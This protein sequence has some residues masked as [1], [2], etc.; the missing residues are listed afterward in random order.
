MTCIKVLESIEILQLIF[1]L[2]T[3]RRLREL[4]YGTLDRKTPHAAL[5]HVRLEFN[6]E[7]R[8]S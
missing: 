5:M 2:N 1:S 4:W 7:L 6:Y 3:D 8:V